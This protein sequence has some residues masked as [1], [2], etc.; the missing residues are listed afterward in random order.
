MKENVSTAPLDTIAADLTRAAIFAW[1]PGMLAKVPATAGPAI[2]AR[3]SELAELPPA[4]ALP[5][6]SDAPTR[7]ALLELLR[8]ACGDLSIC[9][10]R[11]SP[12][13]WEAYA[14][15]QSEDPEDYPVTA[16]HLT[17][18][19]AIALALISIDRSAAR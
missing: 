7:G 8:I 10:Y 15:P 9:P 11:V 4:D 12:E 17:E 16:S 19:G 6:L 1:L 2:L 18:G 5:D 3:Y 13:H 14:E